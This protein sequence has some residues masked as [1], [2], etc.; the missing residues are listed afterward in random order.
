MRLR[1]IVFGLIT[2][3]VL[4]T[5]LASSAGT[6]TDLVTFSA[7][8]FTA[9]PSQ[10]VPVDP[11]TGSFTITF[12]PTQ[13][14]TDST[15]GITLNNLNIV[16]D[17]PLAFDYSPVA[18]GPFAAGELEVGGSADGASMVQIDP[19]SNDFWLY[20][21]NIATAP[22]FAQLGYSQTSASA[23]NQ[24]YTSTGSVSASPVPLPPAAWLLLSGLGGLAFLGRK[25]QSGSTSGL[26]G[27]LAA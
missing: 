10:T 9:F 2:G 1:E 23:D 12:D 25:R 18:N 20:I 16:L 24:F 21:N 8:T 4:L 13:T 5:P 15:T 19:S 3:G 14:Y 6:V 11:V 17:S 26:P 7:N 27:K 22:T